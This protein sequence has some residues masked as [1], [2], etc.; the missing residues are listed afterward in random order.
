MRI[1]FAQTGIKEKLGAAP[2]EKWGEMENNGYDFVRILFP[3]VSIF[4]APEIT[5]VAQLS[6]RADR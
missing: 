1:G 5:Q 2:K 4:L 3:N 6:P